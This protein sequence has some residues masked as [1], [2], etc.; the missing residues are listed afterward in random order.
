MS[1]ILEQ[2]ME[3]ISIEQTTKQL[4]NMQIKKQNTK[5]IECAPIEKHKCVDKTCAFHFFGGT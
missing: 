5:T 3:V 1:L 4:T 2:A